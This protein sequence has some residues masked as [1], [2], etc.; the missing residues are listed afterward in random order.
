MSSTGQSPW[1]LGISASH[2]GAACLLRGNEIICSVQEERL[3]RSKRDRIDGAR[4]SLAVNYC[5]EAAGIGISD[6]DLIAVCTQEHADDPRHNWHLNP[7]LNLAKTNVPLLQLSHHIG[8]AASALALSGEV[9]A[10]VLVVDGAGSPYEDLSQAEQSVFRNPPGYES[11]S[12][13]IADNGNLTPV[14]KQ[15]TGGNEWLDLSRPGMPRFSTLGGMYSAAAAQ[16]FG[17]PLEAGKVMGLA[18]LGLPTI[19]VSD[20]FTLRDG[21]LVFHDLVPDRF[22]QTERWPAQR[23]AYANLASSVQRALESALLQLCVRLQTHTNCSALCYAGG[24]ALNGIA[25]ELIARQAG[26]SRMYIPAAAEDSGTAIGAA[27]YGL[28]QLTGFQTRDR[29]E[30]DGIG[31][32]YCTKHVNAAI[33]KA[34][35]IKVH[36]Q[37]EVDVHDAIVRR[38]EL[39][40]LGGWFE[41]GSELGPRALGH[42]S[43]IADPRHASAKADLNGRVK[44][45]EDFRP[46]APAILAERAEQWFDCGPDTSNPFMLRIW[47]FLEGCGEQVPAVVHHDGSGRAQ[48]VSADISPS[49]HALLHKFEART[50]VPILLNTSFNGRGEPIVETPEDALW[51]MLENGLDFL[52]L[53][54]R[55]VTPSHALSDLLGLVPKLLATTFHSTQTIANG[56]WH[57][58][59]IDCDVNTPWGQTRHRLNSAIW[60]LIEAIDGHRTG[61]EI[62]DLI[63]LHRCESDPIETIRVLAFLRRKRVIGFNDIT[64]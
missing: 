11:I 53:E 51:C 36:E 60:P 45:R 26:F 13:Y 25:N 61:H 46:F 15:G 1:I 14:E 40:Q 54:G 6:L 24:V 3:T 59:K 16:I 5:L 57:S 49:F 2:N 39:R 17:D 31:R 42:R 34:P 29:L 32:T 48:T 19:A 58:G 9:N 56:V 55:L 28:W 44:R 63:N 21:I 37:Y 38:L 22:D 33:K 41:G 20:F 64:A 18:P 10:A 7:Q 52:F 23:Q 62:H 27:F 47:Q 50:G 30:H 43:I 8:H 35:F 4:A 12:M